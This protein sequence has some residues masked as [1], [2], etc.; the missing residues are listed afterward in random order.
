MLEK[1]FLPF[2]TTKDKGTGLGLAVSQR[3]VQS[4][5]GRIEV[6]STE[7]KGSTFSVVLPAAVAQR[8]ASVSTVASASR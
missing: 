7:G 8:A 3:I 5:G 4:A 2:F 1:L 6:R